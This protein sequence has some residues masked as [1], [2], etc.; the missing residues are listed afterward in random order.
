MMQRRRREDGWWGLILRIL[1]VGTGVVPA[2]FIATAV[3]HSWNEF[4]PKGRVFRGSLKTCLGSIRR[5]SRHNA[6]ISTKAQ[7]CDDLL[8]FSGFCQNAQ[9]DVTHVSPSRR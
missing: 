9:P 8:P 7:L 5:R 4:W 3:N 1:F 2:A 6:D